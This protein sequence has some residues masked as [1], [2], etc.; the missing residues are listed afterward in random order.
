MRKSFWTFLVVT[1]W[2]L[3]LC[4]GSVFAAT[5]EPPAKG[6]YACEK[7]FTFGL[8]GCEP[9]TYDLGLEAL[10]RDMRRRCMNVL[11]AGPKVGSGTEGV[12]ALR[13]DAALCRR[14][15]VFVLPYTGSDVAQLRSVGAALKD[16][17]AILGWYI[18]DEPNPEFLPQFQACKAALREVAP[19]Q[20]AVCLFYRPDAAAEFAPHQPLMLTDCYPL[21]YSDGGS[22]LGPHFAVRSGPLMLTRDLGKFNMWGNRGILEWMDLCHALCG[23]RPHWITL[24]VFESGD[25]ALVRWRQPTA[26]EIRLQTYLAVAGGAKGINY[27]R[28]ELLADA[29]G[30]PLPALHGERT[31]LLEEIGRLGAELTPLGPVLVDTEVAEP[32]TILT[33]LRPTAEPGP[34][35][36]VRRLRSKTREVEY[37]VVFN[38]DVLVGASAQ[39]NLSAGFLRA[40]RV[41][42]LRRLEV[43]KTEELPGAATISVA[44]E[45]GGGRIFSVASE[46]EYESDAR[47]IL[48][49]RCL[50]EAGVLDI[51]YGLAEKSG[52]DL[53][54][55]TPLRAAY[56][57]RLAAGEYAE[58]LSLVRQCSSALRETMKHSDDFWAVKQ[59]LEYMKETLARLG[60]EPAQFKQR[61]STT[62]RGLLGLFWSGEA[63]SVRRHVGGLRVLVERVESTA[64]VGPQALAQLS[65]DEKA[66]GEIE[67]GLKLVRP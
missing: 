4:A 62:Y 22:S 44:L 43:V 61:L 13:Q 20:P 17:P 49:G 5:N 30:R 16:E 60:G 21:T 56:Q 10:L 35:V 8:W 48:K 34:R 23:D 32:L 19:G 14:Y 41:Y 11:V 63:R 31:P 38:N 2:L 65:V 58:A 37:L 45:P 40:R 33:T 3:G 18:Q 1:G 39:I 25:G 28:Y 51:D 36:D 54:R 26:A 6:Q 9:R 47:T 64:T 12:E 59:D 42:D 67:Q 57:E 50:N 52:V 46:A 15:G 53:Q 27:F 24:Q 7:V 66:L 29:Y 55:V